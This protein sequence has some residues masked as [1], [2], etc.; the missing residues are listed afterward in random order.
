MISAAK[1]LSERTYVV[2]GRL[3]I[4]EHFFEVPRDYAKP[5]L[6]NIQL[7]ARSCLKAD[8]PLFPPSV[9][10]NKKSQQLPWLLYLQGG[11]GFECRAP[12]NAAWT[13]TLLDKG[14]R[15][16]F[17]DQRGTGLSNA[18]SASTL[19]LRGDETVQ[20]EYLKSFRA[21]SIVRD[22]E[23][24]RKAL[25]A[26]YPEE[27][28]KWSVMGQSFGGFCATTYLSFYPEGL[29]EV[30]L[31]GGLPPLVD[32]PDEVYRRL[33]K[34]VA[35]RNKKFYEKFPEDVERVKRIVKFLGKF[36]E[37]TVRVGEGGWLSPRR[38]LML[39]LEFGRHGGI[40]AV[41]E[42]I[43]RANS[44]LTQFGHLTRPTT[45]AIEDAL[46]FDSNILY[47]LLHE[48]IYCQGQA[49]NWSAERMMNQYPEFSLQSEGPLYFTGEMIFPFMHSTFT[50]LIKLRT[51]AETLATTSTWP[52]LYSLDQLS[53]NEVPVYAA[54]YYDDMYVDF[55]LSMDTA[56][57]IK[58]C[59][60][61]TT[62]AMY[63]DA[64]RSKMQEVVTAVWNLREDVI[65]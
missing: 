34:R 59:K 33:Y 27:K 25:T 22:C 57:K 19:Q 6:G 54:A 3:K 29:R 37:Q 28:K 12:Q 62:N 16:L 39:G 50:E 11:P 35:E 7:F 2:P 43:L 30:F 49:A 17:L 55:D 51:V 4:T 24:V 40:D 56:R 47:A 65:D 53:K 13:Q 60:T 31:F 26:D 14:Y 45:L 32:G 44:D 48:P 41:H 5:S 42:I 58:G 61:F 63:H 38:F 18:I 52:A 21:D 1:I 9:E 23:A 20:A 46:S 36:G 64:V 8:K 10:E 15:L